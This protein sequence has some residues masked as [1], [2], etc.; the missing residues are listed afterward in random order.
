MSLFPTTRSNSTCCAASSW[1]E[2]TSHQ[3]T[4]W[5][6]ATSHYSCLEVHKTKEPVGKLHRALEQ[7]FSEGEKRNV[8]AGH[9]EHQAQDRKIDEINDH[10][11]KECPVL[12]QIGLALPQHPD[13]EGDME[14]PC[15]P[16]HPK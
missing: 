14:S 5:P 8:A 15:E 9:D 13:R 7:F 4:L 6:P 12:D 16:N 11:R 10:H 3:P 2:E 1:R